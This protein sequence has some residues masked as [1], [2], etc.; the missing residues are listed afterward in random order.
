MSDK[1]HALPRR[2]WVASSQYG[3]RFIL[4][5][6]NEILIRA[7]H[8]PYAVLKVMVDAVNDMEEVKP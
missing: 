4:S 6:D 1:P 7:D 5:A 2:P 3:M 8:L